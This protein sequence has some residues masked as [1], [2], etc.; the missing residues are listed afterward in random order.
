MPGTRFTYNGGEITTFDMPEAASRVTV[1]AMNRAGRV[2]GVYTDST[3][4]QH[5]FLWNGSLVST[6]GKYPAGPPGRRRN[7]GGMVVSEQNPRR[8][9]C[10]L[11][12][13]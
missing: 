6:F 12:G 5:G 3:G 13:A 9:L 11:R 2:V 10:S 7:K 8:G 1:T 4:A